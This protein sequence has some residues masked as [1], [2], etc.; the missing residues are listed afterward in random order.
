[1]LAVQPSFFCRAIISMQKNQNPKKGAD[2]NCVQITSWSLQVMQAILLCEHFARFRGRKAVT[3]PSKLFESLYSRVSSPQFFASSSRFDDSYVNPNATP[4]SPG[5]CSP[6][7]SSSSS[8]SSSESDCTTPTSFSPYTAGLRQFHTYPSTPF[9]RLS[10]AFLSTASSSSSSSSSSPV[11]PAFY[12]YNVSVSNP[13]PRSF[14]ISSARSVPRRCRPWSA[15]FAPDS[16]TR[17]H[18]YEAQLSTGQ[19]YSPF[20]SSQ[21][22]YHNPAMFDPAVLGAEQQLGPQE[23]W[24]AWLDAEARRRLL[25]AC[26]IVDVHTSVLQQQRR[27]HECSLN[28]SGTP[29]PPIPLSGPSSALWEAMSAD[30]WAAIL[31]ANPAAGSPVFVQ[32]AEVLTPADIASYPRFDRAATLA[33]EILRLPAPTGGEAT[34]AYTQHAAVLVAQSEFDFHGQQALRQFGADPHGGSFVCLEAEARISTLFEGCPMANTYLAMHHTPLHDLLA[35]SGDSWVFS[36]KVLPVNS[37]LE[38][39]KLLKQWAEQPP[40]QN[41]PMRTAAHG[42]LEGISATKAAIYASRALVGFFS[43]MPLGSMI[44]DVGGQSSPIGFLGWNEDI[45]DYWALY[46]CALICWAFGHRARPA[47]ERTHSGSSG[48]RASTGGLHGATADD[49]ALGWLRLMA[50]MRVEDVA[51]LRGRREA[52]G[53]VGLVRRRLDMD[54]IGGKSRLYVDAVGVLR[55]LEEGINWKWF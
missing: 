41:Q 16:R 40:Q 26:F 1:M 33:M 18:Q 3:R 7:S 11:M 48:D 10:P 13:F 44:G 21:V 52:A 17:R 51:R 6:P 20:A 29:P 22:L 2:A 49:E 31:E 30:Q 9:G 19:T 35:V 34:A 4:W 53:V 54:C 23:R 28:G 55:K 15:L 37:F 27:A 8:C 38:H 39:K 24:Q 43:R 5:S 42:T 45:G 12:S 50:E 36:Q 32:R 25:T 47:N 14:P 46:V